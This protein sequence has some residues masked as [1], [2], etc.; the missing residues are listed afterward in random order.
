MNEQAFFDRLQYFMK[1][2]NVNPYQLSL[3]LGYARNYVYRVF[4][5][6]T[7]PTIFFELR[8]CDYFRIKPEQFW[9][10]HIDNPAI[11]NEIVSELAG[12]SEDRL[13]ALLLIVQNPK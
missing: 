7:A 8:M 5:G 10:P 12:W 13:K 1:K 2:E 9:N 3:D 11:I 4:K 6:A